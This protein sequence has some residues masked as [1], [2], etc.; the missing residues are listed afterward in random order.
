MKN[1]TADP[2]GPLTLLKTGAAA[3][4]LGVPESDLHYLVRRKRIPPPPKDSSGDYVWLP[5][6]L[7]RA[8]AAL[9]SVR[10][11]RRKEAAHAR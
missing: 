2:L 7:D 3:D 9:A 5:D 11:H 8:R 1:L 6:D 10:R 4:A